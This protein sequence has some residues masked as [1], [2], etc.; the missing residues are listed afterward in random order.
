M[1]KFR[2]ISK[3]TKDRYRKE[4]LRDFEKIKSNR[5]LY[6]SLPTRKKLIFKAY[7]SKPWENF[8]KVDGKRFY[9][10]GG[11]VKNVVQQ[12]APLIP[13]LKGRDLD[14]L[15]KDTKRMVKDFL[16]KTTQT[17][18]KDL[19]KRSDFNTSIFVPRKDF[20]RSGKLKAYKMAEGGRLDVLNMIK[21]LEKSGFSLNVNSSS[22]NAFQRLEN[23]EQKQ[24]EELLKTLK[25]D[26][27]IVIRHE[28]KIDPFKKVIVINTKSSKAETWGDTDT[29]QPVVNAST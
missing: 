1:A 15:P 16:S 13:E 27:K 22:K 17:E 18:K 25:P 5:D 12:I 7:D 29:N 3:Q 14:T 10:Y 9:D 24:K 19:W 6:D 26:Q 2:K 11:L 21:Q 23:W 28:I 4:I 20:N 8:Y